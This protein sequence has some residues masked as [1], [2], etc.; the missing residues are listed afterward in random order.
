[1]R[2]KTYT[3]VLYTKPS[4]FTRLEAFIEKISDEFNIG[5]TYFSNIIVSVTE[6]VKNAMTHGNQNNPEKTVRITFEDKNGQL[7]FTV[8]D[9]GQ[10][11]NFEISDI[12]NMLLSPYVKNGLSI[13]QSLSDGMML[14]SNGSEITVM[15]D[16]SSAN[17][18]LGRARINTLTAKAQ[19]IKHKN[20]VHE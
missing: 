15:F 16:I 17:E 1:M 5:H 8:Q 4:E 14:H 12:K 3:L 11:F 13:V 6:L 9:Q 7:N 19:E 18:L 2:E 20:N 10:G